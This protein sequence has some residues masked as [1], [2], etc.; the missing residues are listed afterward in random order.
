MTCINLPI[1]LP[2]LRVTEIC[3]QGNLIEIYASSVQSA[4][5]CP[6]CNQVS[7]RVH[8]YY[9]RKPADFPVSACRVRLR[10]QVKRFRCL[11]EN[12][13]RAIF[14][15]QFPDLLPKYARRTL[16]LYMAHEAIAFALGGQAGGRLVSKLQMPNS[17]DSLFR[18]IRNTQPE[19]PPNPEVIG[20]DDWAK[21]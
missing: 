8:S 15:E 2:G 12:C 18:I 5:I 20:V 19:I 17:G 3:K 10:L 13:S 9:E 14:V 16:R 1:S 21:P 11:T 4:A 7:R 6:T